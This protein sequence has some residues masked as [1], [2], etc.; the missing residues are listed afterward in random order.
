MGYQK[1]NLA[2][3]LF[4]GGTGRCG[5]NVLKD[6][7][8]LHKSVY[9]LPFETRFTIDPD[10]LIPSLIALREAQSPFVADV[11]LK[12]LETF[13]LSLAEKGGIN[14]DK[15][16]KYKDWEL[17]KH[18]HNYTELVLKLVKDSTEFQYKAT[19]PG[20]LNGII[21]YHGR[22]LNKYKIAFS[23]FLNELILSLLNNVQ[24]EL[25]IE[26]NTYNSLFIPD[27]LDL[28]PK[29][30][31]VHMIRDPRDVIASYVTQRWTP[32]I[33]KDVVY[34][35]KGLIA[36]SL[37]NETKLNSNQFLRVKL[38]DLCIDPRNT[39]DS[40]CNL[41]DLE[42]SNFYSA[43]DLERSNTGRWKTQFTALEQKYLNNA[44][45]CE[46]NSLGYK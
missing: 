44:L 25:Y 21:M 4:I 46:L 1:M 23:S 32:T 27:L 8:S 28:C 17:S 36:K 30:K 33:L 16:G 42:I 34:F 40:I 7:L 19:W 20:A 26:D 10:G 35:Y 31:Y 3:T 37:V 39:V 2:K 29:G 5:T 24:K 41:C 45:T 18:F 6:V 12:R 9:S 13:L 14:D 22:D 15:G 11:T 43:F 38:E